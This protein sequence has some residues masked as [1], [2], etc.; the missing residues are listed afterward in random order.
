MSP[1]S[2][3]SERRD[4]AHRLKRRPPSLTSG[5]K[6][7]RDGH[8]LSGHRL[9]EGITDSDLT[10]VAA[11]VKE[12]LYPKGQYLCYAG[13]PAHSIFIVKTGLVA[14]IEDDDRGNPHAVHIFGPGDVFGA[15]VALLGV[16]H[17][18][19]ATAIVDTST[20]VIPG[21]TFLRLLHQF[22]G[23][24]IN[25]IRELH[26]IVCRAEDTIKRLTTASVTSRVSALLLKFQPITAEEAK[27]FSIEP[28]LSHETIALLL[29]TTRRTVT[30][31]F[32]ELAR[33]RLISM[34]GHRVVVLEPDGL[35]RW[36]GGRQRDGAGHRPC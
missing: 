12:R 27:P 13:D 5:I 23:L 14:L 11:D 28:R 26:S 18:G 33:A 3:T 7:S 24:A 8:P 21:S 4:A 2:P 30:R 15:M 17:T 1:R 35:R 22:P 10:R 25:V 36:A 16:A 32:T 34:K 20:V 19:S 9:F 31:A 6:K 29:G